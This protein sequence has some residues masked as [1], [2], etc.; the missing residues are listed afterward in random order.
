[1]IQSVEPLIQEHPFFSDLSASHL[2]FISSSAHRVEFLEGHYIF[3]EGD[4]AKEFYVICDGLVAVEL[5]VPGVGATTLQTV[6]EGEVLGWSWLTPPYRWHFRAKAL[7][8]TRAFVIDTDTLCAKCEEDHDL[9]YE[10]L[11]RFATVIAAR[12]DATRLQLLDI[13][14]S[15]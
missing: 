9:G 15:S 11:R 14:A 5:F 6:G 7:Q 12:L 4:P 13:Y 1:M 8:R 10:L 2:K 3:R